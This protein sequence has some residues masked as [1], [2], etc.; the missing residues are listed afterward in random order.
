MAPAGLP[1]VVVP[2]P[3]ARG[4]DVMRPTPRPLPDAPTQARRARLGRRQ[5]L[6]GMR[7]AAPHRRAGTRER[8]PTALKAPSTGRNAR[9]GTRDDAI[10]TL[11]RAR[12]LWREHEDWLQRAP[13][14]GPVCARPLWLARPEVGTLHRQQSAAVVGVAPLHG[15]RGT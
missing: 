10:E 6:I 2:P 14:L 9:L 1:V 15:A 4:A 5:P 7:P 8:L 13:G 12:P 11:R 3:Q